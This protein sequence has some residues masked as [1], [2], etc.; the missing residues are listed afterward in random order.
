MIVG[1]GGRHLGQAVQFAQRFLAGFFRHARSLD[2]L[3]QL[4]NFLMLVRLAQF[5]LDGLH[6][7]A[8][9]ILALALCH[10]VLDIRL[11]LGTKLQD[12]DLAGQQVVQTV[13]PGFQIQAFQQFLFFGAG[14]RGEIG[15]DKIR[16]AARVVNVHHHRLQVVG[17]RR[18]KLHGLLEQRGDAADQRIEVGLLV[19]RNDVRDLLDL[20]ADERLHLENFF[21]RDP[22]A[23]PRQR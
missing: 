13:E 7:L 5:F 21:Q 10:L 2:L 4:F 8:Q 1:G 6:L 11:N 19:F 3:A 14:E 23:D 9:V 12:L 22:F 18:G 17:K 20:G 15:G 16:Q